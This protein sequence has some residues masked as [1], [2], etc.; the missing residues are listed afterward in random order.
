MSSIDTA[1]YTRLSG[2]AGLAA[3]VGTGIYPPPAPQ[4]ATYPLVTFQ[5]ISG[6]RTHV[7]GP[8][9]T[10]FVDARFQVD[11]WATSSTSARAVAEQVRLA[12]SCYRGTSDTIVI[13]LVVIEN[14]QALYDD[15][16]ELHRIIHDY[17]VHYRETTPN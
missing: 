2:F 13:D 9:E 15:E 5:Q 17:I 6:V 11:S 3:L 14:E 12:L 4:D 7:M 1:L 10:G 8:N 16:V